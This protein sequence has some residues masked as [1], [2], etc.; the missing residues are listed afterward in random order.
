MAS[1]HM[2][3]AV[4][5][6]WEALIGLGSITV[7]VMAEVGIHSVSMGAVRLTFVTQA[8]SSR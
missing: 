2:I 5:C 7:L 6:P 8:A 4:P 3:I 1:L